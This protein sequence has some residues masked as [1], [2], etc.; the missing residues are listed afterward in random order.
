MGKQSI[1]IIS[2]NED[3]WAMSKKM[4]I[5]SV[6]SGSRVRLYCNA[7]RWSSGW[8]F[9]TTKSTLLRRDATPRKKKRF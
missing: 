6:G 9:F 1:R 5:G 2:I 8:Y 7:S 4:R 3:L